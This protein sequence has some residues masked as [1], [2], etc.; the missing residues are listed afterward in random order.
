MKSITIPILPANWRTTVVGA[1]SAALLAVEP[2]LT[3]GTVSKER[4]ILAFAIGALGYFSK[5]AG[6]SGTD[7]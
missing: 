2:L 1:V 6:V 5:D 4:L 3:V 7:K